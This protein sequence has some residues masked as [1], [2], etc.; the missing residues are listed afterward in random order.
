MVKNTA[1][2]ELSESSVLS[3][4]RYIYSRDAFTNFMLV[5]GETKIRCQYVIIVQNI[6]SSSERIV[7]IQR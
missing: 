5:A 7:R 1:D 6:P 2:S 4:I 3:E